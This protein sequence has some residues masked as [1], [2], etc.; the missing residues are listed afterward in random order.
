[1][2]SRAM[3]VPRVYYSAW[4]RLPS[5]TSTIPTPTA[6]MN[7]NIQRCYSQGDYANKNIFPSVYES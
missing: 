4:S 5:I 6:R 2:Q 1:M 3:E 7:T